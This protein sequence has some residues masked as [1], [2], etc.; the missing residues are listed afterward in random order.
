MMEKHD[1]RQSCILYESKQLNGYIFNISQLDFGTEFLINTSL[2]FFMLVPSLMQIVSFFCPC[3]LDRFGLPLYYCYCRGTI[4]HR[5]LFLSQDNFIQ[6]L[7][8][9]T[10]KLTPVFALQNK[11][12]INHIINCTNAI[13]LL[14]TKKCDIEINPNPTVSSK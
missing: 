1:Y 14:S 6:Y 10:K 2:L 8:K 9:G 7:L 3:P 5:L 12:T 4:M 13:L 11:D